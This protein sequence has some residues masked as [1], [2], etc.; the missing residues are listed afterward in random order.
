MLDYS[1]KRNK[2]ESFCRLQKKSVKPTTGVDILFAYLN[3]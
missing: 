2:T 1:P 3:A